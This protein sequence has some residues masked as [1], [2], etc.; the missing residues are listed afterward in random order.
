MNNIT[1]SFLKFINENLENGLIVYHGTN[2]SFSKFEIEKTSLYNLYGRGFYFT[3]SLEVAKCYIGGVLNQKSE[4]SHIKKCKLIVNNIYNFDEEISNSELLEYK[5]IFIDNFEDFSLKRIYDVL[6][7]D[8]GEDLYTKRFCNRK[9]LLNLK[10]KITDKETYSQ[11]NKLTRLDVFGM[12]TDDFSAIWMK[13][14]IIEYL[15][16]KYDCIKLEMEGTG[17]SDNI[18]NI[19]HNVYIVFDSDK[20]DIVENIL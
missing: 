8:F 11:G 18:E 5:K 20:I 9:F 6:P 4:E 10:S 15:K 16:S 3:D 2:K 17:L 14:H 19:I 13:K 12:I 1:T 7:E